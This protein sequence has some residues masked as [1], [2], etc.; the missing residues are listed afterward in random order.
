MKSREL[1]ATLALLRLVL[2]DPRLETVHREKLRKGS[3]EL[4]KAGRSGKLDYRKYF[5]ATLWITSALV[6]RLPTPEDL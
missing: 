5:K 4:E 6:E 3:K 2:A 1:S